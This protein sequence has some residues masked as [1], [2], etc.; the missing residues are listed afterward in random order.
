MLNCPSTDGWI[1]CSH[2]V[3][4]YSE[5][6]RMNLDMGHKED[7]SQNNRVVWNRPEKYIRWDSNATRCQKN[8]NTTAEGE[9]HVSSCWRKRRQGRWVGKIL[10]GT[11]M[12]CSWGGVKLYVHR[13]WSN[14]TP[15]LSC[16]LHVNFKKYRNGHFKKYRNGSK[17]WG[18]SIWHSREDVT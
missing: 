4:C 2:I 5:I 7:E 3:Q 16:W 15:T 11:G 8:V 14:H 9:K 12:E 10:K 6:N 18:V 17:S 13:I 1:W